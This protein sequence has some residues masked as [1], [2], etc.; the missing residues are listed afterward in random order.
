MRMSRHG[1]Q[2]AL[3]EVG[4]AGQARID[5]AHVDVGLHGL[6]AEVAVRYLSGAGVGHLRV[7]GERLAELARA[8]DPTVHVEVDTALVADPPAGDP[9]GL[10]DPVARDLARGA[11]HALRALR[12]AIG[13]TR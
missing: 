10:R 6:A 9:L 8:V 5:T 1:R 11:H 12:M 3:A 13:M 4:A 2:I 7:V